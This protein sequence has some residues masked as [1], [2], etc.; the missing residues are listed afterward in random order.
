M[1]D[2]ARAAD[3]RVEGLRIRDVVGINSEA[4]QAN[5]TELFVANGDG[6]GRAPVLVGLNARRE[7]VNIRLEGR[8]KLFVPIF[9]VR[10]NRKRIGVER[11]K[12]GDQSL[13]DF[14]FV[15]EHSKLRIAN[16]KLAAILDFAVLHRI[17]IS[18]DA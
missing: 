6:I 1:I 8:L 3:F 12:A 17:P 10:E 15:Y 18:K 11:V 7:E 13:G 9:E 16:R 4:A 14:P 2:I 5:R